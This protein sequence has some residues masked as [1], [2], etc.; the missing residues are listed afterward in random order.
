MQLFF[1]EFF[2]HD[3]SSR[4][5][6]AVAMYRNGVPVNTIAE[7]LGI[8]RATVYRWLENRN[9]PT[10]RRISKAGL[11]HDLKDFSIPTIAQW[12]GYSPRNVRY[13]LGKPYGN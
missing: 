9:Q 2:E 10:D 4:E 12:T 7:N 3:Y 6:A 13:I 8:H 5:D 1:R 11:V